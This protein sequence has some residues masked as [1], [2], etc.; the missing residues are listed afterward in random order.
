MLSFVCT[1]SLL[2]D[3][4]GE[5]AQ[6]LGLRQSAGQV[7]STWQRGTAWHTVPTCLRQCPRLPQP[8]WV[9]RTGPGPAVYG[10]LCSLVTTQTRSNVLAR[11]GVASARLTEVS[12]GSP[13]EAGSEL[14]GRKGGSAQGWG[15]PHPP[16]PMAHGPWQGG[17]QKPW[18]TR[19]PHVMWRW[20]VA[21][22]KVRPPGWGA[23]LGRTLCPGTGRLGGGCCVCWGGRR[24][25]GA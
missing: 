7:P 10:H 4:W 21:Q 9:G 12:W 20:W 3:N 1:A 14:L 22:G 5:G 13:P 25:E 2:W 16:R 23:E 18:G 8:S 19:P 24:S 6:N 17:S 11:G 15:A